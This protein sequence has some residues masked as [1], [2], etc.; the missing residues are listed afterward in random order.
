MK[1][2]NFFKEKMVN[3]EKTRKTFKL[4]NNKIY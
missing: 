4:K 2:A 3:Y 1:K